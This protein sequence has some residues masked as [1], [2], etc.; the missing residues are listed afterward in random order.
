[1]WGVCAAAGEAWRSGGAL[2]KEI[3]MALQAGAQARQS[4]FAF[5]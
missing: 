4:L 5:L 3:T 1:M 2:E